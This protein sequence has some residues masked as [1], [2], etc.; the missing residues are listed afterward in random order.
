MRVLM[1]LAGFTR[2]TP[3]WR[4]EAADRHRQSCRRRSNLPGNPTDIIV[5]RRFETA[6]QHAARRPVK[7]CAEFVARTFAM[8]DRWR[9]LP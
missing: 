1:T 4:S 2:T 3:G 9:W 6:H 5:L 8:C 7:L